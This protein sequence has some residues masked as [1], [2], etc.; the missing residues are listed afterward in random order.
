MSTKLPPDPPSSQQPPASGAPGEGPEV[1]VQDTGTAIAGSPRLGGGARTKLVLGG[2]V[3]ALA[4]AGGGAWAALSFFSTGAQP[5][6]ALPAGTLGYASIDLDPGGG[7]KIEAFRT[8]RA[9][10]A[11]DDVA[12]L[13]ADQ[14]LRRAIFDVI[15]GT[16]AG[17]PGL[18][19]DDDIDPWLGSRAALAAVL[20]TDGEPQ[21]VIVV[22]VKDADRAE[23]GLERLRACGD[24]EGASGGGQS[25]WKVDGD[26][27]LIAPSEALAVRVSEQ[28][29]TSNL[30][31]DATFTKWTQETGDQGIATLY[32]A[33]SA[34]PVVLQQ[35]GGLRDGGVLSEVLGVRLDDFTGVAATI[36]F[37][38]GAL[39]MEAA[40]R[41]PQDAD[42][43]LSTASIG[44]DIGRLPGDTAA[45][46]GLSLGDGWA[47]ALLDTLAASLPA[48]TSVQELVAQTQALTGLSLPQDAQTLT[49]DGVILAVG[50]G[51][52]PEEMAS[53]A[54]LTDI[55]VALKLLGD[56]DTIG[57]VLAKLTGSI[58]G[59]EVFLGSTP[60]EGALIVGPSETY[61]SELALDGTLGD[62][63]AYTGVV[64]TGD[65]A[66]VFYLDVDSLD[67]VLTTFL[68]D[69]PRL[70]E[71][72]EALS[73]IGLSTS[74][75][76]G[77]SR[78]VLRVGTN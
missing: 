14:D 67:R 47:K 52:D 9:F 15:A 8:L 59:A 73:S 3:L 55:A 39:E 54:D 33:P 19:F 6:E 61:R 69:D 75:V 51:L 32:A 26:W 27:A 11:F 7:Q 63:P 4:L 10:P 71:N 48:D 66:A 77:V 22:Q 20:D 38:G 16:D 42:R 44:D 49:G 24:L 58:P 36:R 65:S 60:G 17:C 23:T 78:V 28:A 74:L 53:S 25:G 1:L 68:A 18:D 5:S 50:A 57:P 13:D 43:F 29:A 37:S 40:G 30:A 2:G 45:A 35:L 21:P 62:T 76:G 70:L 64:R 41:A 72:V 56:P 31:D 12:G 34:G 46:L